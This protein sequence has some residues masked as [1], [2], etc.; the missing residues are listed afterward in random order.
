MAFNR[1]SGETATS[2]ARS[3]GKS[4]RSPSSTLGPNLYVRRWWGLVT[5]GF[6]Y[7]FGQ[8]TQQSLL[9]P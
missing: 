2:R 4:L 9:K 1:Y 5:L 6:A 8:M 7:Y 3:A